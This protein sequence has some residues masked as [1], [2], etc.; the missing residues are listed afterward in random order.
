MIFVLNLNVIKLFQNRKRQTIKGSLPF[1]DAIDE[2]IT[3]SR[4][5][6]NLT[7]VIKGSGYK[8]LALQPITIPPDCD[9]QLKSIFVLLGSLQCGNNNSGILNEFSALLDQLYKD[10]QISKLLY[11]SLYYKGKNALDKNLKK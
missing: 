3:N 8:D 7:D 11:K 9:D 1:L 6:K 2:R 10:K 5:F 4:Q